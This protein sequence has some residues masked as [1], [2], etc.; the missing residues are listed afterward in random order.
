MILQT[1]TSNLK[2]ENFKFLPIALGKKGRILII[3]KISFKI[4]I[5][6]NGIH[7][8]QSK[9]SK[10]K[11]VANCQNSILTCRKFNFYLEILSL[12][13]KNIDTMQN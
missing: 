12:P 2:L 8:I 3:L 11:T 13:F 10:C 6:I 7:K 4:L 1:P 5:K 9:I